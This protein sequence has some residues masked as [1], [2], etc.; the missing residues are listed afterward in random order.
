M[1]R[2]VLALALLVLAAG[3]AAGCVG[4]DG[5]PGPASGTGSSDGTGTPSQDRDDGPREPRELNHSSWKPPGNGS[6]PDDGD[7][8]EEDAGPALPGNL[9]MEG[10]TVAGRNATHVTF[11]WK[12]SLPAAGDG[13][14][15]V[16]AAF[17]V[18]DGLPL[19]VDASLAWD[20]SDD[21][22][23]RVRAPGVDAYCASAA[24]SAP[25][26]GGGDEACG[27]RTLARSGWDRWNLTVERGPAGVGDGPTPFTVELT[28]ALSEPWTGPPVQPADPG[29]RTVISSGWPAL[30]QADIRPGAKFEVG[31]AN[32]VFSGP[33]N[34]SLYLGWIAHGVAG[35]T[36]GDRLALN[37]P[38]PDVN[39]TLVYCSWGT[40]EETVT[41]P[42]LDT[43]EHPLAPNDLALVRLP[44]EARSRVHPATL[45]WGG[46]TGLAN[47]GGQ[48][49][50]VLAFGNT[51]A[52]DGDQAGANPLDPQRGVV[53]SGG[54]K[55]AHV[56][57]LPPAVPGDSGSPVLSADGAAVGAMSTLSVT[58]SEGPVN[59]VANLGYAVDY[60]EA[61]TGLDV[62]LQTWRLFETPRAQDLAEPPAAG[63]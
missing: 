57:L 46:P 27:V 47:P 45:F 2:P 16:G 37:L 10:A 35:M 30:D 17:D 55:G 39:A 51:D 43:F 29:S 13:G 52:R 54:E 1:A 20:R 25:A 7:D 33:D 9:S 31:T 22:D 61:N 36:P 60:L 50:Q 44:E 8:P 56:S 11:R 4:D 49:D 24:P 41:C 53:R 26:G 15:P 48:G 34:R 62:E 23:L 19:Q 40:I 21:L 18:P 5:L 14:G 32:F 58:P 12:G 3:A 63:P 59:G 28:V 42:D 6:S 38:G